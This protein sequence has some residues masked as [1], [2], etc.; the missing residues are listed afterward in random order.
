MENQEPVSEKESL[1]PEVTTKIQ[2]IVELS[3]EY[4]PQMEKGSSLAVAAMEKITA[5]EDE[6]DYESAEHLCVRVRNA[7]TKI[8]GF[9][10]EITGPL[11]ELKKRFMEYECPLSDIDKSNEY[12]RVRALMGAFRQ[13][14]I[15]RK[16]K[17]EAEA[18]MKKAK[19]NNLVDIG[20]EILTNLNNLILENTKLAD[21]MSSEYFAKS[22]VADWDERA[23]RYSKMKPSLKVED[24]DKCFDVMPRTGLWEPNEFLDIISTIK[25]SEPLEKWSEELVKNATPIINAW[26]AKIPELKQDI[27][28][29]TNAKD[30]FERER[31]EEEQKAKALAES[32]RRNREI[33]QQSM[34]KSASI[35]AQANLDKLNNEFV[36]QVTTQ[37]AGDT[38]PVKY[39][40]QF[41]DPKK[42][43]KA[44]TN[45]LYYCMAHPEF[46]GI[47]KRDKNK[48]VMKDEAGRTIY[49][50]AVQWWLK[51]FLSKCDID[52]EDTEV[53]ENAK[54]IVRK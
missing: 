46:P 24:Y 39:V 1:V 42:T 18:A 25:K 19:E 6:D 7:Y 40:L 38:G 23:T 10:T 22:T 43:L 12:N 47:E 14:E 48:Q 28:N 26:R 41:T 45:I 36:E 37:Q 33:E 52:I 20:A 50:D 31:L 44:F 9:R 2:N 30:V 51:F 16:K 35:S 49:I 21:T 32:E 34:D 53:F 29:I 11:D 5:I 27:I 54:V 8:K 3:K 15:E 4:L 13:A 17:I